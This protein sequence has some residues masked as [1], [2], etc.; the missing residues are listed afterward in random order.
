MYHVHGHLDELIAYEDMTPT[1][2]LNCDC[3]KLAG[4]ALHH[5]IASGCHISRHLPDEDLVVI[6]DGENVTGSYEK[7]ITRNWGNKEA[8]HHYHDMGIIPFDLFDKVYWDGIEKVL[9]CCP[10]MFSIWA[11]K[12]VSCFCGNNHL[13]HHINGVT[14]DVCPNCG[15][16]PE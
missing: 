11:M 5:A 9:G 1:E 2:H 6:L 14:V 15:C 7:A 8:R 16:H 12:Q 3:D 13:L 10:E 4:E